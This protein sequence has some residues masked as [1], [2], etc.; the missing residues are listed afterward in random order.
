MYAM[1]SGLLS[2]LGLCGWLGVFQQSA[3]QP[4]PLLAWIDSTCPKNSCQLPSS[5]PSLPLTG[6]S[7]L[8][9]TGL[10]SKGL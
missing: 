2:M 7:S 1:A 4:G 3:P 10:V 8:P 5:Q 6:L 9:F